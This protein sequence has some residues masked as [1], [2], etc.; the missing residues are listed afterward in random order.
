MEKDALGEHG[1][2]EQH[3]TCAWK[4]ESASSNHQHLNGKGLSLKVSTDTVRANLG[5]EQ[6]CA[7]GMA[8][9]NHSSN[10]Q[11]PEALWQ[12]LKQM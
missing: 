4:G 12:R 11:L 9:G 6:L 7:A 8:V 10:L 1:E 2:W 5:T 3:H